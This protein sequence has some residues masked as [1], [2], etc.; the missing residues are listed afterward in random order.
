MTT[1]QRELLQKIQDNQAIVFSVCN[2][3][4]STKIDREDLAQEIF[5]QL[6]RSIDR[7]KS[8]TKFTTWMYRVALNVAI[9]FY[10]KHRS[11]REVPLTL[12]ENDV[13]ESGPSNE[14]MEEHLRRVQR[15]IDEQ[16]T[17]DRA[18][19]LLYLERKPHA[20]IAEI[21]GI[22]ETNTAT[23]ISRLKNKL[24]TYLLI[25]SS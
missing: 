15:F 22:T 23:R 10:R 20:E 25:H 9:S 3:Y 8:S 19:L 2:S 13:A 21:L 12:Q 11:D 4:C 1:T 14:A 5:Y 16:K 7:Y 6:W 18:L 24:K 17:L